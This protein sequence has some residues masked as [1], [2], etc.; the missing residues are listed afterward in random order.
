MSDLFR[1]KSIERVTSPE[2]LNDYI[3]VKNQG[4]WTVLEAVVLLLAGACVWGVFGRLDSAVQT[5]GTAE[6]GEIVCYV[7][8]ADISSLTDKSFISV[9]EEE[10][11]VTDIAATPIRL[12]KKKDGCILSLAGIDATDAG[13]EV[14][15]NAAGLPD[16]AYKVT[17]IKERVETI[18]FILN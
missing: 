11:P 12:D 18:S 1:K 3:R 16:G 4:V 7:K 6:N 8:A 10:Y 9:N 15:A 17:V 2:Q 13:Y 5:A 14:R